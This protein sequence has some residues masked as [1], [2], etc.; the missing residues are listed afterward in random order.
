MAHY[1]IGRSAENDIRFNDPSVAAHHAELML[2]QGVWLLRDLTGDTRTYVNGWPIRQK[3]VQPSDWV[4]FGTYRIKVTDLLTQ[5]SDASM[6]DTNVEGLDLTR[7]GEPMTR[8]QAADLLGLSEEATIDAMLANYQ[9]KRSLIL[10][11]MDLSPDQRQPYEQALQELNHAKETLLEGREV[12]LDSLPSPTPVVSRLSESKPIKLTP[13]RPAMAPVTP[14]AWYAHPAV[15]WP[16]LVLCMGL[17]G[18]LIYDRQHKAPYVLTPAQYAKYEFL[19][20]SFGE[21]REIK[22]RNLM[23]EPLSL[24]G[25]VA[26]TYDSTEKGFVWLPPIQ[27]AT[28]KLAPIQPGAMVSLPNVKLTNGVRQWNKKAVFVD[29]ILYDQQE[30]LLPTPKAL[31]PGCEGFNTKGEIELEVNDQ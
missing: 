24:G 3:V 26:Y 19:N 15:L 23:S 8:S 25:L 17:I 21:P 20:K 16:A 13:D 7:A 2:T 4:A 22:I 10:Q 28:E 5:Q 11:Q 9:K 12:P 6:A 18:W 27:G 31:I 29:L 30:N 14:P 1:R